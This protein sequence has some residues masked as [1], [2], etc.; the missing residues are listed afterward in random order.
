MRRVVYS[1]GLSLDGYI[2][3]AEGGLN[4][5][6]PDA[7]LFAS[8]TE[9]IH[10]MG[11]QLMGRRLYEAMRPWD[12]MT[13]HPGLG[14]STGEWAR[15]WHALDKVVFSHTPV[16][17][18]PGARRAT[19]SLSEEIE[20]LRASGE[21]GD[22]A[23]GGA[24]LAASAAS[25]GLIDEYRLRIH[26]LLLGGGRPFFPVG[27]ER[28][29]LELLETRRFAS[30][31]MLLRYEVVRPAPGTAATIDTRRPEADS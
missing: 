25:L 31:V 11:S 19:G 21:E 3:D 17:L 9:E 30:G 1:M 13:E 20:S 27:P 7:E 26:P 12:E 4:W 22:I 10:T 6:A 14:F 24:E 2:E 15:A 18:G 29:D 28:R 16:P 8:H 23:I 5:T